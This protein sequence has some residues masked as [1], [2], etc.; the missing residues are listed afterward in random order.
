MN[1]LE[2]LKQIEKVKKL[3]KCVPQEL[4]ANQ[5]KKSCCF[6]VLYASV[7]ESYSFS[8]S[9]TTL[10]IICLFD[11]CHTS[12]YE[13]VFHCGLVCISLMTND[14]KHPF[15]CLFVFPTSSLLKYLFK[16]FAH[17]YL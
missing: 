15:I 8:I 1:H 12:G 14:A 2:H 6:E 16:S 17:F 9:L 10:V 7:K 5:K 13:V 4:T 11:R 3:D